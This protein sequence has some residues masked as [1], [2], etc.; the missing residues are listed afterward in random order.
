MGI[1]KENNNEID[2][3]EIFETLWHGKLI[4]M[5]FIL[6]FSFAGIYY[7]L[8]IPNI[9]KSEALV[10]IADNQ[11]SNL[12]K[13]SSQF[14]GLASLAGIDVPSDNGV[15][16]EEMALGIIQSREFL[17][18]LITFK[19]VVPQLMA[20]KSYDRDSKKTIFDEEIY[21]HKIDKWLRE[22]TK[23]KEI[24][25]SYL[26]IHKKYISEHLVIFKDTET[27]FI[28][29][30]IK[31]VSPDFSYYFLNLIIQELNTI[32]RLKDSKEAKDSLE[33]LKNELLRTDNHNIKISIHRLIESQIQT[34]AL[35][36]VRQ[37]YLLKSID[38]PFV[39]EIKY[40]PNR[41]LIC[42]IFLFFGFVVSFF[43]VLFRKYFFQ[44]NVKI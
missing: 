15:N 31:H 8:S 19:D 39:P 43:V 30:G 3:K 40:E 6:L 17:K 18:H 12:S 34:L 36:N 16:K 27:G 23:Y 24:K 2:L 33:Y 29:I 35:L 42:F 37:D 1:S 38:N 10:T 22:P 25:P 20:A 14:G 13:M 41:A 7:S 4:I 9:Y 11:D 32:A 44:N 21:D 28:S 5:F 26:E